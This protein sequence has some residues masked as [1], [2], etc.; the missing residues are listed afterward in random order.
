MVRSVGGGGEGRGEGVGG[1]GGGGRGG[2]GGMEGGGGGGGGGGGEEGGEGGGGWG[3]GGEGGGGERGGGR[4]GRRE[5]GREERD[6]HL[7]ESQIYCTHANSSV[8]QKNYHCSK[9]PNSTSPQ[10]VG[11]FFLY[12]SNHPTYCMVRPYF[13]AESPICFIHMRAKPRSL[14]MEER[15]LLV[16]KQFL[17]AELDM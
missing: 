16:T 1:R 3:G 5:E 8:L 13:C 6:I 9:P 17:S 7:V 2:G 15:W 14:C 10:T 4:K 11:M 12:Q